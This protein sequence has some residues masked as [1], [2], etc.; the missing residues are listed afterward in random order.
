MQTERIYE[1]LM[2]MGIEAKQVSYDTLW[3]MAI[4][5]LSQEDKKQRAGLVL[6]FSSL[7]EYYDHCVAAGKPAYVFIRLG[8]SLTCVHINNP[9]QY[10]IIGWSQLS[11]MPI[12]YERTLA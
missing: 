12:V 11:T 5:Q 10:V 4:F 7:K 6:R 1:R 3:D 9:T 2:R 8:A